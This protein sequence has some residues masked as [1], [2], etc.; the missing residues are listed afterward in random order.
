[1]GLAPVALCASKLLVAS[2]VDLPAHPKVL[3]P[4][5]TCQPWRAGEEQTSSEL[6]A[7]DT[8]M[9]LTGNDSPPGRVYDTDQPPP[10]TNVLNVLMATAEM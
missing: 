3:P 9:D 6:E 10:P 4:K 8:G 1:M 5:L 2:A 7:S